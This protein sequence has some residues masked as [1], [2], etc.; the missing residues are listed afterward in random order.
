MRAVPLPPIGEVGFKR[1][2]AREHAIFVNG[3]YGWPIIWVHR[4]NDDRDHIKGLCA[5]LITG[6]GKLLEGGFTQAVDQFI[7]GIA[8]DGAQRAIAA[9]WAVVL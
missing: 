1:S 9:K 4:A 8:P 6:S 5:G 7:L 2:Q 3:L